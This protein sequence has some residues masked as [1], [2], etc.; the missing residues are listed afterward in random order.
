MRRPES[1]KETK[2]MEIRRKLVQSGIN[3]P[4]DFEEIIS[5]LVGQR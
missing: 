4:E 5:N 3:K 2:E 1:K